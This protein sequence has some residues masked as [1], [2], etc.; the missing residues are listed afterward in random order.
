M[1]LSR[2]AAKCLGA[3]PQPGDDVGIPENRQACNSYLQRGRT[4]QS[5]EALRFKGV[6]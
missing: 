3:V 6:A 2:N 4:Q 5:P 1:T